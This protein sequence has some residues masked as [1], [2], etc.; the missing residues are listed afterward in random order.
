MVFDRFAIKVS[1]TM[2][3]LPTTRPTASSLIKLFEKIGILK[4]VSGRHHDRIWVASE[5]IQLLES[6]D[7]E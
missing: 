4:E 5:V 6:S 3:H 1:D 7:H 2:E